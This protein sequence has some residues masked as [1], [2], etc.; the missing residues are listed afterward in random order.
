MFERKLFNINYWEF[1]RALISCEVNSI[2]SNSS[3]MFSKNN[4]NIKKY[5]PNIKYF[6]NYFLRNRKAD[7][8]VISQPRRIL[9][10]NKYKN[11]YIDYYVDYLKFVENFVD[12]I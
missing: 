1:V 12:L 2:V 3:K 5:I 7:V 10:K 6:K 4:F 11:I 8:L 9:Q